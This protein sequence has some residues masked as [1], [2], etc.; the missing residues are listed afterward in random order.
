MSIG[1][2]IWSGKLT[3]GAPVGVV[4]VPVVGA[5]V[6]VVADPPGAP[7]AD[8]VGEA[9]AMNSLIVTGSPAKV[10]A[11]GSLPGGRYS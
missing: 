11:G 5:G 6:V 9:C 2:P 3:P 7:G 8:V 4:G 10:C 1:A